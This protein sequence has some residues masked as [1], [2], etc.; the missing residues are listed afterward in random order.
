MSNEIKS[1]LVEM[2]KCSSLNK[3]A[4]QK[5]LRSYSTTL[6]PILRE[7]IGTLGGMRDD[8]SAISTSR[9]GSYSYQDR[10]GQLDGQRYSNFTY[11]P[12]FDVDEPGYGQIIRLSCSNKTKSAERFG[13]NVMEDEVVKALRSISSS[14]EAADFRD[15][16]SL[17][18]PQAELDDLFQDDFASSTLASSILGFLEDNDYTFP[19]TA[20]L[21]VPGRDIPRELEMDSKFYVS[22]NDDRAF[23][24]DRNLLRHLSGCCIHR[25]FLPKNMSA[26]ENLQRNVYL[27]A[28]DKDLLH[29]TAPM[30]TG[31]ATRLIIVDISN[32]TGSAANS[33]AMLFALA[34]QLSD[35]GIW[36]K[37]DN[38]YRVRD[39]IFHASFK[40]VLKIYLYHVVGIGCTIPGDSELHYLP[41]GFLGVAANITIGLVWLTVVLKNLHYISNL[42]FVSF[43]AQAGGD[44]TGILLQGKLDDVETMTVIIR[45]HLEDYVG[46]CKEFE[47][48]DLDQ[49]PDGLLRGIRFCKKRV[50][51]RRQEG[52]VF[53]FG[54]KSIPVPECLST[55]FKTPN[56]RDLKRLWVTTD[57]ALLQYEKEHPLYGRHCQLIR[58][59]FLDKFPHLYPLQ[60]RVAQAALS[61]LV[62]LHKIDGWI[63]TDA[64]SRKAS[65]V[66]PLQF[67]GNSY[68]MELEDKVTFLLSLGKLQLRHVLIQEGLHATVVVTKYEVSRII[69][70]DEYWEVVD[71]AV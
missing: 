47:V 24:K 71:L 54:E 42:N 21:K 29:L 43:S 60:R 31:I 64:A 44:D 19:A 34:L 14:G 10:P 20:S 36:D 28:H 38:V 48:L 55:S 32:F 35:T 63:L 25:V 3:D 59:L 4:F 23:C 41:G 68:L 7:R 37:L 61:P 56:Q 11:Q 2:E 16:C 40:D 49:R 1:R 13:D 17:H 8:I 57:H 5:S 53:V 45:T 39:Q 26:R 33:W 22:R 66:Q 27:P 67:G 70:V 46:C 52:V 62:R 50:F 6:H 51:L 69:E 15:V 58:S 65:S 30:K 9:T 12:L 18:L